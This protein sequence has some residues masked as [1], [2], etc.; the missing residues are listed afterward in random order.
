VNRDFSGAWNDTGTTSH[1]PSDLA[2]L[3]PKVDENAVP[4]QYPFAHEAIHPCAPDD[5]SV[6]G[7][8]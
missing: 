2:P 6:P 8:H 3:N 5:R 1:P 4:L 7:G